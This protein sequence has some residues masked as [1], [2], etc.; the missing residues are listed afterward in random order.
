MPFV[1][2]NAAQTFQRFID[3]V[4]QVLDCVFGYIDDILVASENSEQHK[5]HLEQ[6][7]ERL[8]FHGLIK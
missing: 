7:F 6:V 3:E 4:F 1:L 8:S 5:K 2:R